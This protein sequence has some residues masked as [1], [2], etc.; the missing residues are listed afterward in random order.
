MTQVRLSIFS[1]Y[2]KDLL[3][4]DIKPTT[5]PL[6]DHIHIHIP[7]IIDC[8]SRQYPTHLLIENIHSF[9]MQQAFLDALAGHCMSHTI[10]EI[11]QHTHLLY[12]DLPALS[13]SKETP[14]HIKH[15]FHVL[16]DMLSKQNQQV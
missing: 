4:S 3:S 6:K 12:V 11:L 13:H 7:F 8:L 9:L 16:H 15:D 14:D 5:L 1:H 2:T 10:P